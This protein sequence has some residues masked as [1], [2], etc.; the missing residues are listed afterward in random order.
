MK[1]LAILLSIAP[2]EGGKFQYSLSLLYGLCALDPAEYRISVISYD[3]AWSA[4]I[5][6]QENVKH[7]ECRTMI[8]ARFVRKM[9]LAIPHG[10][11]VWRE[12]G[13]IIN[14]FHKL[15]YRL[16]PDLVFYPAVDSM[17]YETVFPGVVSIHDL[18][19]R[20]ERQFPEVS[21]NG[22]FI[23]RERHYKNICHYAK[24]ILVD[25]EVGRNHVVESYDFR[26]DRI[27]VLPY[28][29]PPYINNLKSSPKKPDRKIPDRFIFYPAQMWKHKN[30]S[31]IIKAMN[32]LKEKGLIVNAV[33]VGARK[34]GAEDIDALI[35]TCGLDGQVYLLG[36][37][38][39]E[40]LVWLYRNAVALVMPTFFG[41]TNVPPLEAFALGCP[42]ITS[43]IYAIPEQVGDAAL[44]VDPGD[45]HD[46]AEKIEL[47]WTNEEMRQKLIQN[48]KR[49]DLEWNESHFNNR[50]REIV[51]TII[52]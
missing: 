26:Y 37:V 36:Y 48:G 41:P 28:V 42:V 5:P 13:P 10:L 3:R 17:L 24:A 27:H 38:P 8:P 2:T 14:S 40:Q 31:G 23:E 50:V 4:Y 7:F 20:Y 1:H 33:F 30:H 32:Y 19:H 22:V 34:S 45:Y 25:S 9:L 11:P 47:V 52:E 39:G 46:I 49:K 35:D 44:L 15:L 51:K 29:K 12:I 21:A 6:K 43:N 18:M 16:K